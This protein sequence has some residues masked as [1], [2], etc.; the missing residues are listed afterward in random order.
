MSGKSLLEEG[1]GFLA[2]LFRCSLRLTVRA[3]SRAVEDKTAELIRTLAERFG[4][5]EQKIGYRLFQ[6]IRPADSFTD[7][8]SLLGGVASDR[9]HEQSVFIAEGRVKA[10]WL[11]TEGLTQFGNTNTVISPLPE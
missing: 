1:L 8:L 4:R 3:V 11:D 7:E 9:F 6:G 2:H 10:G 5:R